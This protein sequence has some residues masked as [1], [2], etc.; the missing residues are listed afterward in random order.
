MNIETNA[1]ILKNRKDGMT[2]ADIAKQF[3]LSRERIHQILRKLHFDNRVKRYEYICNTCSSP[4][5]SRFRN[6]VANAKRHRFCS[7]ECY[8]KHMFP[9]I[10]YYGARYIKKEETNKR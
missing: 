3:G 7:I 2:I 5:Y 1:Q 4:F 10:V 6:S 9:P 8:N